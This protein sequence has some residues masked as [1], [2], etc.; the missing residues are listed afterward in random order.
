V[1]PAALIAAAIVGFSSTAATQAAPR[2][3]MVQRAPPRTFTPRPPSQVHVNRPVTPQVHVNRP[4]TPQLHVNRPS[5]FTPRVVHSQPNHRNFH[6]TGHQNVQRT[7]PHLQK[8]D[9]NPAQPVVDHAG[10]GVNALKFG[11]GKPIV[12]PTALKQGP[13][14]LQQIKPAFPVVTMHNKF[15]PIVK[16]P[17][18]MWVGGQKKF[19]VPVGALGIALISGSDWYPDGYVS[20]AGPACYGFTPDGCQL[21]WRMVDFADGG[22]EPQCVQYCPEAGPP[23]AAAAPLP[24]APAFAMA[25]KCEVTI[26][27]DPNFAGLSAPTSENQPQLSQTGWQNEISS[28]Q[29]KAGTWDFFSDENFGG[30]SMRMTAG[31]YPTLTPEWNKRI[32]SF[33]CVAPGAP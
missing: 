32:G 23:P 8:V 5:H 31:Q 16:G 15:W 14:G 24:P 2:A 7:N 19:F 21:Q 18:F 4:V 30:E 22:A 13:G 27:S 10:Q 9:P 33:M 28:L 25:G 11:P 12:N 6:E 3:P 29:V 17:K 20:I 1:S 26:F